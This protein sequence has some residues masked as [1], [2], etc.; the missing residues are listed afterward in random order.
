VFPTANCELPS[1]NRL[2]KMTNSDKL[3]EIDFSAPLN[4]PDLT[5]SAFSEKWLVDNRYLTFVLNEKLYG[6]CTKSVAEVLAFPAITTL[7]HTPKWLAGIANLRGEIITVVDL[8]KFWSIEIFNAPPN[9]KLILLRSENEKET[10][11]VA[12]KVDKVREVVIIPNE[13]IQKVAGA[14]HLLGKITYKDTFLYLLDMEKLL[15]KIK[16]KG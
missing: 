8:F 13:D 2:L 16:D 6:V 3:L 4:L 15:V 12:V 9:P 5:N 1:A 7:P 11:T 14:P 10:A